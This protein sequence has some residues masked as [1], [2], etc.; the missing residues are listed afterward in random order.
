MLIPSRRQF[1]KIGVRTISGVAAA[2]ALGRVAQMNALAAGTSNYK[3][4]VCI[5]LAGGNDG[6]NTVI[7]I[8]TPQQKYLAYQTARQGL[9]LAQ[10]SLLP[11]TTKSGALY[12]LHPKMSEIQAL[13]G[14]QKAAILANVGTLVKPITRA[15]YLGQTQPV[16][17]SLFSHSDQQGQWQTVNPK[18]LATTGWAGRAADILT[19]VNAPSTYPMI[20]ST[21]G[22]DLFCTGATSFPTQVP[23]NA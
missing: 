9:A 11:I 16:P 8:N 23:P 18:G 7:P 13:F 3:A 21:T 19:G 2:G 14:S 5:F 12:G 17:Q 1:L 4:L 10:G 20:V 15:Q 22:C 6:N